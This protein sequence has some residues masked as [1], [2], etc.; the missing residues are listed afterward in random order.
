MTTPLSLPRL[1]IRVSKFSVTRSRYLLI[2]LRKSEIV[3]VNIATCISVQIYV[4]IYVQYFQNL[5]IDYSITNYNHSILDMNLYYDG[6]ILSFL[7]L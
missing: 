7:Q 1:M 5:F 3:V 2:S 6:D 4:Q